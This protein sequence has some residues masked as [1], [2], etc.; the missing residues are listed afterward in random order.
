MTRSRD[1]DPTLSPKQTRRLGVGAGVV[2]VHV[3]LFS[4]FAL[5]RTPAPVVTPVIE[6]ELF[7]PRSCLRRPLRRRSR[8][9]PSRAAVRPPRRPSFT[10]A[11]ASAGSAG[12]LRAAGESARA[13]SRHR[14][15][16]DRQSG[17]GLRSGRG[18][19]RHR[20]GVRRRRRAGVGRQSACFIRGPG[21]SP[22]PSCCHP[23]RP[24]R[25]DKRHGAAALPHPARHSARSMSVSTTGGPGPRSGGGRGR[26]G[27]LSLRAAQP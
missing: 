22:D 13:R 12:T 14:H 27:H 6:V 19:D 23:G 15:R 1:A 9:R 10:P 25:P 18:G 26:S 2:M 3:G 4:L 11:E 21:S 20:I 5:T 8:P 24:A 17:A 7:A 16:S